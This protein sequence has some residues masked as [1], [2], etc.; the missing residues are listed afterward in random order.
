M[1][2][3]LLER[4][5]RYAGVDTQSRDGSDSYPSTKGQLVLLRALAEELREIGCEEVEMD[6]YGYVTATV[7]ATVGCEGEPVIGFLAH[8][9]TSPDVSGKGV[10]VQVYRNYNPDIPLQLGD[11]ECFLRREEFKELEMFKGHTLLTAS[12]DTLLGADDKA[13]IAEI[14][15]AVEWLI[16]NPEHKHGKIRVAFTPDEEIGRGVDHFDVEK[17]GADFAYTMDSG[18]EGCL[19]YEN[20][21]AAGVVVEVEGV[22][23]HPGYAKGR[24]R[25]ALEVLMALHSEL[26][27]AEKPET[28]EGREGFFHLT[29]VSGTVERAT[30]HYIIRDHSSELFEQRKAFLQSR[31]KKYGGVVVKITDQY[32]NMREKIEPCMHIVDRAIEAM[33]EVGVEPIVLPIRGGTDGA[34]LSFMGLPCINLFAGG[35]NFHSRYE[36]LSLDSMERATHVIIGVSEVRR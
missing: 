22:N 36:Y 1:R 11:S 8:V 21:N 6:E 14:I 10:R 30:A 5:V 34:R 17:F 23:F 24:M 15:T 25:N 2:K 29:S 13:G 32:Y 28:T 26:P 31:A 19:E 9:D 3:K 18:G 12:G 27:A 16:Q 4:F 7:P 20:F 33:R 35:M